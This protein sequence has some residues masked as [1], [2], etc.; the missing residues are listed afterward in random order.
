MT[1]S[2]VATV[3]ISQRV[4]SSSDQIVA[5]CNDFIAV[6]DSIVG[7]VLPEIRILSSSPE[8]SV[9]EISISANTSSTIVKIK[10]HPQIKD[11]EVQNHVQLAFQKDDVYRRHKRLAVFDM[12]STLIQQEVID[13]IAR[14]LG[15]EDKVSAI[16]ARAM[17]GE[18]DFSTSLRERVALL[19]GTPVSIFDELKQV[20]T[21][22]P[23]AKNLVKALKKL[24]YKTAVLSGGF[25]PLT[26]WLAEQLGLDY[27]YANAMVV[28]ED[29]LSLQGEV[30]G[31]I[32]HA[33]KKRDLVLEIAKA[34]NIALEQVIAIGDGA[35]DLPMMGVAGLGVA[36][37]AKPRV[38]DAA[39]VRL[40]S[41]SLLNILYLFG[42]S[43][44]EISQLVND[45]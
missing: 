6:L 4:G 23:G 43:E 8:F 18:L 36:F 22:T 38:Q 26:P 41:S 21:L 37:N 45:S 10:Q 2:L 9:A 40:N 44:A 35:N 31:D 28:S 5:L 42:L 1:T 29:G 17:N 27:S 39:P 24:G 30:T 11:F 32:V 25:K 16:T 12:D 14:K 20:I 34:N 19:K 33:E 7:P 3:F 13:E 15:V